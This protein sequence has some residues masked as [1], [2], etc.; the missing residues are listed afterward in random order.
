MESMT[1]LLT[2]EQAKLYLARIGII[3]F[4]FKSPPTLDLLAIIHEKH[5]GTV[6]FENLDLHIAGHSISLD[7]SRLYEKI[8]IRKRGGFCFE[9]NG[10][11][12]ELLKFLKF[13]AVIYIGRIGFGFWRKDKTHAF[14]IVT[15]EDGTKY[16]SDVALGETI[17][18]PLLLKFDTI[19]KTSDGRE[20]MYQIL[21][22]NPALPTPNSNEIV[23]LSTKRPNSDSFNICVGF[24]EIPVYNI[25]DM[26]INLDYLLNDLTAA[27]H[28]KIV[29]TQTNKA[30]RIT[31]TGVN[32]LIETECLTGKR[33]EVNLFDEKDFENHNLIKEKFRQC[34]EDKFKLCLSDEELNGIDFKTSLQSERGLWDSL[35]G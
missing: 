16:V 21:S 18:E 28:K 20:Y 1:S 26:Q 7:F 32:R 10:L 8:V 11:Y 35:T 17:I 5:V 15:F 4:D 25:S 23:V 14:P 29:V 9:L 33:S 12:F 13:K 6:P 34:L 27:F 19:Q 3:E 24:E 22:S 30:H 2:E 31:L